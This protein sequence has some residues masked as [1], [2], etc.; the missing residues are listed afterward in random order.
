MMP[1]GKRLWVKLF[2]FNH[3]KYK[4]TNI[5]AKKE[6]FSTEKAFWK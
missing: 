1:M 2:Q 3:K 6:G 4:G 5:C